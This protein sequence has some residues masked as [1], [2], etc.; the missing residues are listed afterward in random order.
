MFITS[1]VIGFVFSWQLS[2]VVLA[3]VPLVAL[4]GA[5]MGRVISTYSQLGQE[6]YGKAGGVADEVLSSI[7]TVVAFGGEDRAAGL[8]R[9]RLQAALITG[10]KRAHYAGLG[11]G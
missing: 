2:L 4:A 10:I 9:D 5:A 6:A 1:L 7:R 11:I 3:V 8:Y